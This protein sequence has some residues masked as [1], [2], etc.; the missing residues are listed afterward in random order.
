MK[1]LLIKGTIFLIIIFSISGC[2]SFKGIA[3][4]AEI[5]TYY[6][7]NFNN[8]ALSAPGD[9]NIRYTESLRAKIRNESR[10][11]Y[12]EQN[13]D[14]TFSGDVSGY[15]ITDQAPQAG[16]TSVLTKLEIAISV[17]YVNNLDESK[18][19]NKTFSFYQTFGNEENL[20]SIQDRLITEIFK[21]LNENVF[22]EAFAGW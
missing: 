13:P 3:I 22:N 6:I 18:N 11:K 4:P 9:V 7:E 12:D 20:I 8:L 14:I 10:L 16:N 15:S 1:S 5:T 21:Q 17:K 2:Y 19:W